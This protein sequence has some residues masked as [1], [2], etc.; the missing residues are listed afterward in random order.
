MLEYLNIQDS[1]NL[2]LQWD[3]LADNYFQQIKFLKYTEKFNHCNQRYYLCLED[4]KMVSAAII[5]SIRLDIFTFINIKSPIKMNIVGV[6]CSVSS[7]GIF[8]NKSAIEALKNHIYNEEKGF[9]LFLNLEEKP[10]AGLYALGNTLPT[11]ILRNRFVKWE[12]YK[13]SLRSNYRR[14]LNQINMANKDLQ[15]RKMKCKDFTKEMHKL[16]IEVYKR[17][18]SKLEK[19]SLKFF[20]NLPKEFNLLVCFKEDLIIGWNISLINNDIYYFFLGGIDYNQNKTNG[21]YLGL[22]ASLIKDGIESKS[23]FIELGQTAEIP[24][25]RMGGMP[26]SRFMEARH[27]NWALNKLLIFSSP[28]MEYKR[29]LENTNAIKEVLL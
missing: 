23:E 2:P 12:N 26:Q 21:A 19:L 7:A 18:R 13:A 9:V 14:R 24:K 15:F 17:S 29:K 1:I 20:Q 22:L 4:D 27:S 8:G 6:P 10:K 25:M 11:I 28:L 16:Y 5:Y 3:E